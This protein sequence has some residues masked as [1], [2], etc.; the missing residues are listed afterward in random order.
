VKRSEFML[1]LLLFLSVFMVS[2][3][4]IRAVKAEGTIWIR[5]DGRIDPIGAPI[6]RDGDIYTLTGDADGINVNRSNMTLDGNEHTLS[7]TLF[8]G[9]VTNVTIKNFIIIIN[10][11]S[12]NIHLESCLNVT[13]A[14]NTVTGSPRSELESRSLSLGIDI[15]GGNSNVITGNLIID[16]INGI[17][18]ESTTSNNKVFGNKITGNTRGLSIYG[19]Q[20][21]SIYNNIFG[22]NTRDVFITGE[23]V[24]QGWETV[25]T[26]LMNTFDNG[27][28]GNYWSNY[29]GTDNNG[30][31]IGDTS[32]IVDTYNRD[33]Y[34]LMNPVNI[35]V[36][37]EFPSWS[38]LLTLFL[39]ATLVVVL[40]R[41]R[42]MRTR[43]SES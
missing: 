14:N 39:A 26:P 30:D 24:I 36:I 11:M 12:D 32:Y 19:S 13:I 4:Q 33:N 23:S 8:V 21:N 10:S 15:W 29:H 9:Y 37:P 5:A 20:N 42:L 25:H 38:L 28:T 6:Q 1:V 35:S 17:A 18:F 31:G 7:Q 22:N 2:F 16:M 43:T 27:T 3:L 34:P 41:K 40:V